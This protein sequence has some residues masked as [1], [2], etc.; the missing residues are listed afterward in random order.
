MYHLTAD[1]QARRQAVA[2]ADIAGRFTQDRILTAVMKNYRDALKDAGASPAVTNMN[3]FKQFTTRLYPFQ[4]NVPSLQDIKSRVLETE[5]W[6]MEESSNPATR[7]PIKISF[8][9]V[10]T[11]AEIRRE[12]I[13]RQAAPPTEVQN[14]HLIEGVQ[15]F[16]HD[17][18]Y[19]PFDII[20]TATSI[21]TAGSYID[22]AKRRGI[23][24]PQVVLDS[25]A[26]YTIGPDVF[27]P[28]GFGS[29]ITA[30]QVTPPRDLTGYMQLDFNLHFP[31]PTPQALRSNDFKP[32]VA[33]TPSID[34]E[35]SSQGDP[36]DDP[37]NSDPFSGNAIKNRWFSDP[38]RTA[39]DTADAL[40]KILYKGL[41]DTLQCICAK[42]VVGDDP[43][44]YCM[45]TGDYVVMITC[46][47]LRVPVCVQIHKAQY[48]YYDLGECYYFAPPRS[49]GDMDA[50]ELAMTKRT[51]TETNTKVITNLENAIVALATVDNIYLGKVPL[52]VTNRANLQGFFRGLADMIGTNTRS[53]NQLTA[54]G[55]A[56]RELHKQYTANM[57]ITV[58]VVP[59]KVDPVVTVHAARHVNTTLYPRESPFYA[60]LYPDGFP[61]V[62]SYIQN[63]NNARVAPPPRRER[64]SNRGL[65]VLPQT[66]G[67]RE[68]I[69]YM[70]P[71]RPNYTVLLYSLVGH[72]VFRFIGA[73]PDAHEDLQ[74]I[75]DASGN[76]LVGEIAYHF[77]NSS[78][79]YFRY[80][81]LSTLDPTIIS[82]LVLGFLND[83]LHNSPY[84]PSALFDYFVHAEKTP[85]E[86]EEAKEEV[87]IVPV[88]L[89]SAI[90]QIL[91]EG[92]KKKVAVADR[93]RRRSRFGVGLGLG[94]GQTKSLTGKTVK[95]HVFGLG[96]ARRT[97]ARPSHRS[98]RATVK[99]VRA[100]R[101][102]TR[103]MR[104]RT[105]SHIRE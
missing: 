15:F 19:S 74:E 18:G 63:L 14:Q 38:A 31:S 103:K 45:F 48:D 77:V 26:T 28:L 34:N 93:Y 17:S 56:I 95:R 5:L 65:L 25:P 36:E 24:F 75:Y 85:A 92:P 82:T 99:R 104:R 58:E 49:Q 84:S 2:I 16:F 87:E 86:E 60:P 72:T 64:S 98:K 51:I 102:K 20:P 33:P 105:I 61:D 53:L 44:P 68:T 50:L 32:W 89:F 35:F 22:P 71:G 59:V 11:P 83:I 10:L 55:V 67:S 3:L 79:P 47:S 30:L 27:T 13:K 94:P 6:T 39:A 7:Q 23:G 101:L 91:A 70:I 81:G 62:H 41:G 97:R 57:L 90:K 46:L 9:Q 1:E 73:H 88:A 54:I 78:A 37:T 42:L 52:A 12:S 96:G 8:L 29:A 80:Y 76:E 100:P 4:G 40:T 43:S 69:E 21:L 66:G